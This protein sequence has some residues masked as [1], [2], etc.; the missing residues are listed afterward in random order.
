M[1]L[2]SQYMSTVDL[3][4]V[5]G[6]GGVDWIYSLNLCTV[7]HYLFCWKAARSVYTHPT[8]CTCRPPT[9]RPIPALVSSY[10]SPSLPSHGSRTVRISKKIP[11]N[12]RT[13]CN[14]AEISKFE[15]HYTY[16]ANTQNDFLIV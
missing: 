11:G 5:A 12:Q 10:S 2:P 15:N 1:C 14:F 6:G 3:I 16:V 13:Y 7:E 9:P 4:P 8:V